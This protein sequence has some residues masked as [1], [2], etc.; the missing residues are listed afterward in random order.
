M[1]RFFSSLVLLV[2]LVTALAAAPASIALEDQFGA[3]TEV[4]IGTGSPCLVLASDQRSFG[5][6]ISAWLNALGPLPQGTRLFPV[7][8]LSG[9]PFFIPHSTVTDSLKKDFPKTPIL[10][11]WKGTL[12]SSLGAAKNDVTVIVFGAKGETLAAVKGAPAPA[13]VSAILAALASS[14]P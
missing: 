7:G 1:R 4:K 8:S 6:T 2:P 5:E 11:D 3:K 14:R 10:L 13:G 12:F 9:L